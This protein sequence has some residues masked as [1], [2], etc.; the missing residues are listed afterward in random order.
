[1]IRSFLKSLL[2]RFVLSLV[3]LFIYPL[4]WDWGWGAATALFVAVGEL[5]DL[6]LS[7]MDEAPLSIG[8]GGS[9]VG[10][11]QRPLPDLNVP[12]AEAQEEFHRQVKRLKAR[13]KLLELAQDLLIWQIRIMQYL[14]DVA[15]RGN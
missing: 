15:R 5:V 10:P 12:S 2:I 7:A 9:G 6:V 1:M 13:I 4:L 8:G 14:Q 11:S 3:L